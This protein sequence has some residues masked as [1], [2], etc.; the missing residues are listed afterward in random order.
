MALDIDS[1]L[2]LLTEEWLTSRTFTFYIHDG[3]QALSETFLFHTKGFILGYGDTKAAFWEHDGDAVHLLDVNGKITCR[4]TLLMS[5]T[6]SPLLAGLLRDPQANYEE[7]ETVQVLFDNGSDYHTRIQSFDMF[8]TLVARRCFDPRE[9]FRQV[10]IK[11]GI[12]NF[13][14]RR[15]LVEMSIFGR[16]PYGIDDIYAMLIDEKLLTERQAEIVKAMELEEE[17]DQLIPMAQMVAFVNPD[18]IIISDMY[19]PQAFLER[20]L[21]E[22]CGLN[23]KLYLSNYGKHH[24]LIWP[25][26]ASN[27]RLRTHYGDNPHADVASPQSFG[28]PSQLVTISKWERTEEILHHVGLAPYAH[29]IREERLK[30]FHR[31]AKIRNALHAQVRINYPMMLLAGHWL[32]HVA[33]DFGATRIL[34][35]A[36]DCTMLHRLLSSAH[37]IRHGMPPVRYIRISR[38]LCYSESSAYE[39]YIRREAGGERTLLADFVGSGKSLLNLVDGAGLR[40]QVKPCII[41]GENPELVPEAAN[42]EA[43]IRRNFFGYRIY[44]EALNASLEGSAVSAGDDDGRL[45]VDTQPNE[46]TEEMKAIVVEMQKAFDGFLAAIANLPPLTAIP[47]L[48]ILRAGAEAIAELIPASAFR[49]ES[50]A[51]GQGRALRRGEA[52]R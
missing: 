29:V 17:W 9:V 11:S 32:A 23:N 34:A 2:P 13:A 43:F 1:Q 16:R 37:F 51:E 21:R 40:G 10:E 12:E 26:I 24:R 14:S 4:M 44:V 6:G 27:H 46:F 25:M 20:V 22:K 47:P 33:R 28:I 50:L 45:V 18:D 3:A 8:D 48:H 15:H 36:R 38:T 52:L 49:L 5:K 7:T 31:D 19:L 35:A 41:V 39:A 42:I 30:G